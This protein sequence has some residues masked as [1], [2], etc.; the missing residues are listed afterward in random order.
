MHE[1]WYK[2]VSQRKIPK[3]NRYGDCFVVS[4]KYVL[5]NAMMGGEDL[6]LVHGIPTGQGA[7]SGIQY[8][9]A[10]VEKTN[11]EPENT[12]ESNEKIEQI[13]S[14]FPDM[15]VIVIDRSNGRNIEI[16]KPVYYGIGNIDESKTKKYTVDQVRS[17]IAKHGTWGPWEL[18]ETEY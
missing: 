1:N 10:W 6:V 13:K 4:A 8:S 14:A 16:P 3:K 12:E 18:E 11:K 5:D 15:N 17:M 7:I 2:K 9:H